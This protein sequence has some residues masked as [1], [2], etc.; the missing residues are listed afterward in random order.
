MKEFKNIL[1]RR[2]HPIRAGVVSSGLLASD[3][4]H[5]A[6]QQVAGEG[7]SWTPTPRHLCLTSLGGGKGKWPKFPLG[8]RIPASGGRCRRVFDGE[9]LLPTREARHPGPDSHSAPG[10]S[11]LFAGAPG[12]PL[13]PPPVSQTLAPQH[14]PAGENVVFS[15]EGGHAQLIDFGSATASG[16]PVVRFVGTANY[17]PPEVRCHSPALIRGSGPIGEFSK[18]E[19]IHS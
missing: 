6:H 8:Q 14:G 2:S 19:A 10:G 5:F 7:G 4:Q 16:E 17:I 12:Q 9:V 11:F 18:K 13:T 15:A 3:N 1:A